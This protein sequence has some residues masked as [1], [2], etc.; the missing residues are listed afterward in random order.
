MTESPAVQAAIAAFHKALETRKTPRFIIMESTHAHVP[1]VHLPVSTD[2]DRYLA[3]A[4]PDRPGD[5]LENVHRPLI[6]RGVMFG[7][8]VSLVLWWL[9]W[10]VMG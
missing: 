2:H 1:L 4:R 3:M 8:P 5:D 10:R 7:L 6:W 9:I